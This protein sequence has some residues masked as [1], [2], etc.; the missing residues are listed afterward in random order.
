MEYSFGMGGKERLGVKDIAL[1]IGKPES[2]VRK[3]WKDIGEKINK[4]RSAGLY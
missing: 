3:A 2:Y 1:R 4:N